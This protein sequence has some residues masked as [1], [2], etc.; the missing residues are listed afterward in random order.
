MKSLVGIGV[1]NEDCF[2]FCALAVSMVSSWIDERRLDYS[3][4]T[5]SYEYSY[6]ARKRD[7]FVYIINYL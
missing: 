3:H 1:S 6:F 7:M 2:D 5:Y 4:Q